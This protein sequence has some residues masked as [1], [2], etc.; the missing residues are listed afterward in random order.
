MKRR[1]P[2]PLRRS[3][4]PPSVVSTY[5][6]RAAQHK[7]QLKSGGG[8]ADTGMEPYYTCHVVRVTYN[9]TPPA[10]AYPAVQPRPA[11]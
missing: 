2:H 10:L 3:C 6:I 11:P 1:I 7:E 8:L 9:T 4:R 5:R